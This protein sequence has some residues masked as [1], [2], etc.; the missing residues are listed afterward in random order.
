MVQSSAPNR[1]IKSKANALEVH[2]AYGPEVGSRGAS[3]ARLVAPAPPLVVPGSSTVNGESK[4]R[5]NG[6]D[7]S[8]ANPNAPKRPKLAADAVPSP[9]GVNRPPPPIS[10]A[11]PGAQPPMRPVI[12]RP[13]PSLFVPKKVRRSALSRSRARSGFLTVF[14]TLAQ[15]IPKFL[16]DSAASVVLSISHVII[17]IAFPSLPPLAPRMYIQIALLLPPHP[18]PGESNRSAERCRSKTE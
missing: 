3:D 6:F 8:Q 13:P 1:I 15:V 18:P 11:Q 17:A 5:T 12:K 9:S 16:S 7:E 4:K 14:D 2:P 10:A